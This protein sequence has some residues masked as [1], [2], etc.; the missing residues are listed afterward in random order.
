MIDS[1]C[2]CHVT[3]EKSDFVFYHDFLTPEYA[4]TAR[5]SQLIEIKGHG[6]VY[7]QHVLDNGDKRTL[8]LSE[9]L[10]VLQASTRFFAPSAP[11]KLGHY[12]KIT[13]E[14]FYLYHNKPKADGS[15]Q[16]IFSGLRDK[17]SDLYWLQASVLVQSKPTSHIMSVD[18]SF[19]L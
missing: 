8:V 18:N 12:A 3:P 4:K 19:D 5:Q 14:R 16:L 10:Y 2:N 13:A 7:V 1:G 11:I 9:V 15:P 17:L 6:T